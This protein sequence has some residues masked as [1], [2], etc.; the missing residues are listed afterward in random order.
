MSDVVKR[1]YSSQLREHQARATRRAVVDAAAGL[2]VERGYGAT[3]IDAIAQAAGVSRKTVYTSVGGKVEAL[4]LACDWAIAGDDEPIPMLERPRIK[5]A[6][7]EPDAGKILRDYAHIV[8]DVSRRLAPLHR[9]V[10][11]A[12]GSDPGVAALA[13][14]MANQRLS[15]MQAIVSTLRTKRQLRRD[16]TA[17]QAADIL[18][19]LNDP[20]VYHRLVLERGWPE[21][22][23]SNWLADTLISQ[24]LS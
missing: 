14:D 13:E 23:Y 8:C 19:L 9:V 2:F 7:D 17:E 5:A 16:L 6:A 21:R 15:G 1:H 10:E 22:R 11:A 20:N 12:K 18:W 3:T 24:L 4:K